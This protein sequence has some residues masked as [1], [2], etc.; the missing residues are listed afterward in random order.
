MPADKGNAPA[1]LLRRRPHRAFDAAQRT[2]RRLRPNLS[3]GNQ[4]DVA[5][6]LQLD[7]SAAVAH[8]GLPIAADVHDDE[9]GVAEL[10]D[11]EAQPASGA[12]LNLF[13]RQLIAVDIQGAACRDV[14]E[15]RYRE[16]R[17]LPPVMTVALPRRP[18]TL[19]LRPV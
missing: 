16:I 9:G 11:A 14:D 6:G 8:H 13:G 1:L 15:R 5:A 2:V 3:V 17:A 19:A 7:A 18:L 12:E 10:A 4:D